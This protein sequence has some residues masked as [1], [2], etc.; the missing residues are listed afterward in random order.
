MT[1]GHL[2]NTSSEQVGQLSVSDASPISGELS[3]YPSLFL[4][5]SD[6]SRTGVLCVKKIIAFL[7]LK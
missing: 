1:L 3:E 7:Q 6:G 4:S 5:L 2:S